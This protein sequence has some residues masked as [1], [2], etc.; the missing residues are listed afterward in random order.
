M[1]LLKPSDKANK[2][3]ASDTADKPPD[4]KKGTALFRRILPKSIFPRQP[5]RSVIPSF[6]KNSSGTQE[7]Q[8][9]ASFSKDSRS[10]S[11]EDYAPPATQP[12]TAPHSQR[13]TSVKSSTSHT[14]GNKSGKSS[15]GKSAKISIPA[16]R[17][18]PSTRKQQEQRSWWDDDFMFPATRGLPPVISGE[19]SGTNTVGK[20]DVGPPVPLVISVPNPSANKMDTA[21]A[22]GNPEGR[23]S[24]TAKSHKP[25]RRQAS[26]GSQE[27]W[28]WD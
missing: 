9:S 8:P 15:S 19:D 27:D 26:R 18:D 3:E 10:V 5:H 17:P 2:D 20:N 7:S 23:N 25:V 14:T 12:P 16:A 11:H 22:S 6:K 4:Q 1:N 21:P 24:S 28:E 13:R